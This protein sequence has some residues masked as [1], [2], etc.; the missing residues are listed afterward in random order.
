M[1]FL[2]PEC[3]TAY[4]LSVCPSQC[5]KGTAYGCKLEPDGAIFRV[6]GGVYN[7]SLPPVSL[8]PA[9][10]QPPGPFDI[11]EW[12]GIDDT[13]ERGAA[14]IPWDSIPRV[15]PSTTI[16][17]GGHLLERANLRCAWEQC[18][19][20]VS[21]FSFAGGYCCLSCFASPCKREVEHSAHCCMTP[22]YSSGGLHAHR[23]SPAVTPPGYE[24]FGA[25]DQGHL[26]SWPKV[27][28]FGGVTSA[29]SSSPSGRSAAPSACAASAGCPSPPATVEDVARVDGAIAR[30][31]AGFKQALQQLGRGPSSYAPS[32]PAPSPATGGSAKKVNR[33]KAP[34]PTSRL[35]R[36][37]E[38]PDES[39]SSSGGDGASAAA[40]PPASGATVT[41]LAPPST[42]PG[43]SSQAGTPGARSCGAG[44]GKPGTA[45]LTV[46]APP[47][48]LGPSEPSS[49]G[50]SAVT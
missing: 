39:A 10:G 8:G 23:R 12:L 4:R 14:T 49:Q 42:A 36:V 26:R 28:S 34:P 11:K 29:S 33:T 16:D 40:P 17:D 35:Y 38:A 44:T 46:K 48:Q 32:G 5:Q 21:P 2:H 18:N 31:E 22:A 9:I 41:A 15:W 13:E 47:P 50:P 19:F 6:L 43:A 25:G 1:P 24:C 20:F 27:G 45:P 7:Q 3:H 37:E 30:L